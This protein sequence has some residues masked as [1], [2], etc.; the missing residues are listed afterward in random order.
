[1]RPNRRQV[2]IGAP[3]L[4]APFIGSARSAAG[5]LTFAAPGG[6]FQELYEPAI[7]DPYRARHPEATVFWQPASTAGQAL[8]A[9]RRQRERPAIDVVLL[10]LASAR[11]A[12]RENLV[13]PLTPARLP[14]LA[15]LNAGAL[16]PGV[17]G[18]ALFT[19]PL[20]MLFDSATTAPPALWKSMWGWADG[21]SLAIPAPPDPV[22]I[23][24]TIAAARVFARGAEEQKAIA[25]A[26]NAIAALNERQVNWNPRPDVYH[27]VGD[28][29]ARLGVGWNMQAQVFSDRMGG[30]LGVVLP[31]EGTLSR[32]MT[33]NL[34]RNAPRPDA[35]VR[36]IAW[37][38]SA[39]VQKVMVERL[40]L[41][42]VNARGRYAETALRRTANTQARAASAMAVDWPGVEAA[43]ETILRLWRDK[44]LSS[45]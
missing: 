24:F 44:I 7:V 16:F 37:M 45:G 35:A 25:V 17:A 26:V 3:S 9:L 10:D 39:E 19:E 33:V 20:V 15:E 2:L 22:G 43:R 4:A 30:R 23:A 11:E 21:R 27:A 14:V 42:P 5:S 41:G 1:M 34:V 6:M 8:G 13:E 36:F 32:V 28:G 12:A 31:E 18:P 29:N 40:Y 38:L